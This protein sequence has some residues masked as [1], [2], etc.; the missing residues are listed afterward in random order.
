[1]VKNVRSAMSEMECQKS[2][3]L[4]GENEDQNKDFKAPWVCQ[5]SVFISGNKLVVHKGLN[6]GL[7]SK[8]MANNEKLGSD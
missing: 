2:S 6:G 4:R 8:S 5:T 1:M 7:K 3:A